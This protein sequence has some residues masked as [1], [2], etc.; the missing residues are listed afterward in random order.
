MAGVVVL[1]LGGALRHRT[2]D[3][4]TGDKIGVDGR[5]VRVPVAAG[6]LRSSQRGVVPVAAGALNSSPRGV[7]PV[8]AGALNSSPLVAAG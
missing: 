2:S 6:T 8:A 4:D 3:P 7:V 5:R 1:G